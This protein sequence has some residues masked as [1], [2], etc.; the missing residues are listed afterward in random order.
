MAHK[1]QIWTDAVTG[2]VVEVL[3]S[4]QESNGRHIRFKFLIKPGGFKPVEHL[5]QKQDET[6]EVLRGKLT[7]ILD[8]QKKIANGGEK[9]VLPMAHPHTHYN[10]EKEDLV[11]IQTIS[12]ALD[13]EPLI[14]SILGLARDGKLKDGEPKFL[15]AMVWLRH[16]KARTYVAKVP[17]GAQNFLAL[18]LGPVGRLLGY[19]AVY[20]EYSGFDA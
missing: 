11:M 4:A 19:K 3:E 1:G 2:D 14:E 20:K 7:Y 15:Q 8:G 17:I 5:H 6:F 13:A 16:F 10:D 12:P 9:V 18:F